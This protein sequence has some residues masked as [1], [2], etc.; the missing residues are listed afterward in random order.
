VLTNAALAEAVEAAARAHGI[1]GIAA[2]VVRGTDTRGAA[3]G[4]LNVATNVAATE[5]SVFQIGSITKV[6]TGTL[7]MQL[8]DAGSVA[9]DAPIGRYLPDLRIAGA[10]IADAITVRTLLAH[11]SGILGDFFI[12]TG[13]NDDAT[14]RYADRCTELR[15]LTEPGIFSYCNS[16]YVILG[17]LIEVISGAPW[18]ANVRAKILEPLGMAVLTDPEETMLYRA[19]AGH[20]ISPAGEIV[21]T[22]TPFLPRSTE[23][24]GARLTMSP[25]T[26]LRFARM[27]LRDGL[28]EDGTRILSSESARAMREQQ[29]SLPVRF[30]HNDGYGLSWAIRDAS[31]GVVGHNGG[32]IGQSAF[33]LLFPHADLAISALTNV[34]SPTAAAAFEDILRAVAGSVD[35]MRLREA[36]AADRTVTL[37]LRRPQDF[38]P[39]V[40]R[41]ETAMS[42]IVVHADDAGLG[43][44]VVHVYDDGIAPLPDDRYRLNPIAPHEFETVDARNGGTS[45]AGF[46]GF[47]DGVPR[48]L[49]WGGRLAERQP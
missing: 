4:T 9:L 34:T 15:Y 20:V 42:E 31:E 32:T 47:E 16:G 29:V 18:V 41:Y 39:L 40:G 46:T 36:P 26:L 24:A 35:G 14:Q 19:A 30:H 37:A 13:N 25:A 27:H 1:P 3:Y 44:T 28:A 23:A 22:P 45:V 48:Y 49:F 11:T 6:F 7:V 2:A 10:P 8:V 12:G 21:L 43:V 33:L 17:R 5:D 38:A